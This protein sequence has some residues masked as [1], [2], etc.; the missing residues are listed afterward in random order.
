MHRPLTIKEIQEKKKE[1]RA[2]ESNKVRVTNLKSFQ[3]VTIQLYGK[4]SKTAIHQI[5]IQLGP[6]KHIDVPEYRLIMPQINNLRKKGMIST[7]KVGAN[8]DIDIKNKAK[9]SLN[10]AVKLKSPKKS[11]SSK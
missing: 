7:C 1:E 6:K 9:N 8:F 2:K 5:T 10:K 4:K 11:K 3:T